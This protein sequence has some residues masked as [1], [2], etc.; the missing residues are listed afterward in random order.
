MENPVSQRK[1][2]ILTASNAFKF[3]LI[4]GIVNLFADVTYEGASSINGQFLGM[5]GASAVAIGII[6]G[7]GEFLG[8][9]LRFIAG[10]ISDKTGKYWLVTF[11]GYAINLFA[12]PA[13]AL[14]GNWQ[15]AAVLIIAERVGRAIRKPTVEAMLSYTTNSLG[16]GWV[17]ALNNALDQIGAVTGPLLMALV[18]LLKGDYRVGYTVLLASTVLAVATLAVARMYFPTP[19]A[20]EAGPTAATAKGFTTS[21]WL[22]MLGGACFAAGLVSFELISFHFSRT[23]SVTGEWIPLLFAL[24]M[25]VDGI[26]GLIFGRLFDKVGMPVVYL[27]IFLSSLFAPF[28]FFGS[29]TLVIVGMILWGIGFA[30]QDTLFKS[31]I[32]GMLPKGRRN[33]AFG[34]FYTGYG[35]GWLVGSVTTGLLYGWSLLFLVGFSMAIQ[36]I[37]LP[38]FFVATKISR[39]ETIKNRRSRAQ[40]PAAI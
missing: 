16:K 40:H 39:S 35:T 36:L 27:A 9:S 10:Y 14:A 30:A 22:Y 6:A 15:V 7:V 2:T 1:K 37:S 34:L 5:L 31:I 26:S 3:V 24:A 25:A 23:G 13:L 33:L 38:A 21:Y 4:L 28:V 12:V 32:A 11:T 29:F 8:Y 18:L 20:L 19:S 17:Y